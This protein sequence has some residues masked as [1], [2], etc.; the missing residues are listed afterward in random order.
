MNNPAM[1]IEIA[2]L[3]NAYIKI[4]N[5]NPDMDMES[6]YCLP[7]VQELLQE[8]ETL[9]RLATTQAKQQTLPTDDALLMITNKTANNK[10]N[11]TATLKTSSFC[12]W[13]N[14][15]FTAAKRE[16][17]IQYPIKPYNQTALTF[18]NESRNICAEN[19]SKVNNI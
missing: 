15:Q 3:E 9:D 10:D 14:N 19:N 16:V 4:A 5:L 7:H 2:V 17:P 6:L 8:M 18:P 11:T 13:Y 1:H 12:P